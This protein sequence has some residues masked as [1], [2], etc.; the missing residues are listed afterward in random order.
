MDKTDM[1]HVD[2]NSRLSYHADQDAR[3]AP[4]V[5]SRKKEFDITDPKNKTGMEMMK[6]T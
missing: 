2:F 5:F 4:S 6:I 3:N 1:Q